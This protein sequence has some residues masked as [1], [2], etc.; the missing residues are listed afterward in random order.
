[1]NR[2]TV[3]HLRLWLPVLLS[4]TALSFAMGKKEKADSGIR[5]KVEIWEGNFMPMTDPNSASNKIKPGAGRVV[6]VFAAVKA[7]SEEVR[8]IRAG[9]DGP[10]VIKEIVC[11]EQ[12]EF[13]VNLPPGKYSVFVEEGQGW[14]SNSIDG[15]GVQGAV[16]VEP[17]KLA[18]LT[19]KITSKATF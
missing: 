3:R 11:N 9:E 7:E 16:T 1:M 2:P 4:L 5:G 17:G 12:G 18:E 13:I 14:Y 19:I 10:A 15:A 6:R 8:Q